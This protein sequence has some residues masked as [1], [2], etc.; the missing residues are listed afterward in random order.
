MSCFVILSKIGAFF[1]KFL[2]WDN[3]ALT[4]KVKNLFSDLNK[5]FAGRHGLQHYHETFPCLIT[6]QTDSS[7]TRKR[8]QIFITV[9]WNPTQVCCLPFL[10]ANSGIR[11][12]HRAPHCYTP[13]HQKVIAIYPVKHFS[14]S[15][16]RRQEI[17]EAVCFF[18]SEINHI[19]I[20]EITDW[21]TWRIIFENITNVWNISN[22]LI[23]KQ[24]LLLHRKIIIYFFICF[25]CSLFFTLCFLLLTLFLALACVWPGFYR[26]APAVTSQPA[27]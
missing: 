13:N 18:W 4:K 11:C 12:L 27:W 9:K 10:T 2:Q 16:L 14:K 8:M 3:R 7:P 6:T 20:V 21:K 1:G 24:R 17:P 5:L 25:I 19:W 15:C 23:A 26:F 22:I